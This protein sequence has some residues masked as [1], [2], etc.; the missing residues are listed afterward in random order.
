[1]DEVHHLYQ[2]VIDRAAWQAPKLVQVNVWG[3]VWPDPLDEEP[4]KAFAEK[5]GETKISEIIFGLGDRNFVDWEVIFLL[6][7]VRPG[8]CRYCFP[9]DGSYWGC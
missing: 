9:V 7:W 3:N 1:M 6:E 8:M 2:V 4:F 5:W